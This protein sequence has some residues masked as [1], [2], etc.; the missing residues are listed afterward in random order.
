MGSG[1]HEQL[2]RDEAERELSH[3]TDATLRRELKRVAEDLEEWAS[4]AETGGWST[5]HVRP[6][7]SRAAAIY[8]VLGKL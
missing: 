1:F 7:R 6:M 3:R 4:E 5:Q 2:A 8:A